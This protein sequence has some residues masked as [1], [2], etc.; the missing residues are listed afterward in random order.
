MSFAVSLFIENSLCFLI[1]ILE[2][3]AAV[4]KFGQ[5]GEKII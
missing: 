3:F 2:Q 4:L 5:K 1:A